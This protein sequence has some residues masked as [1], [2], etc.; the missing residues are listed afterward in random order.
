MRVR[1]L[2]ISPIALQSYMHEH[3]CT[4]VLNIL[5]CN[6][7]KLEN[8]TDAYQKDTASLVNGDI[9]I[10]LLTHHRNLTLVSIN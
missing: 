1:F 5:C 10:T 7:K 6:S 3:L 8:N 9:V 4:R 2:G